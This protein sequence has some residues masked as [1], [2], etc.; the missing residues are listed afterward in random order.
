MQLLAPKSL[1]K[2]QLL[3]QISNAK[4]KLKIPQLADV[5]DISVFI[6]KSKFVDEWLKIKSIGRM[7]SGYKLLPHKFSESSSE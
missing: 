7:A 1:H 2:L 3:S 6:S 4:E 5:F